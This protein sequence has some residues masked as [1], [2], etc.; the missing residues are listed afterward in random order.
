MSQHKLSPIRHLLKNSWHFCKKNFKSL[1]LVFLPLELAVFIASLILEFGLTPSRF[2][3]VF[4]LASIFGI[5]LSLAAIFRK[6]LVFSGGM[7]AS[8][9]E[10]GERSDFKNIYREVIF[11]AVPIAW[12]AILQSLYICA[13]AMAAFAI[14]F[15]V[16]LSPFLILGIISRVFPSVLS[17]IDDIG[18]PLSIIMLSISAIGFSALNIFFAMKVWFASYTLLL[19][20]R[21]GLDALADSAMLTRGKSWQIFWRLVLIVI[22]TFLPIL[23]IL[24]PVYFAILVAAAKQ[25]AIVFALGLKPVFPPISSNLILWRSFLAMIAN[26]LWA[27]I[28]I[29]LGY[30][31][32]KDV[33]ATA[34]PFHEADYAV[35]RKRIR[36]AIWVGSVIAILCPIIAAISV[37][38]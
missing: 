12:L 27:P 9:I 28:F 21:F 30:F 13:V 18:G 16:F 34:S 3:F 14:C 38:M 37:W 5:L 36:I 2:G 7:I 22:I 15:A 33:K 20:G 11:Q 17:V 8:G 35:A 4:I 25:M 29:S 19:E 24:G 23:I 10:K 6:M 32:W 1:V 31:L 26:L